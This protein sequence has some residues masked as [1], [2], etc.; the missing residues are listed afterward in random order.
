VL[1]ELRGHLE[2]YKEWAIES[3][4]SPDSEGFSLLKSI[5]EAIEMGRP[6]LALDRFFDLGPNQPEL[7]AASLSWE[8]AMTERE[9]LRS[10]L[11]REGITYD[12]DFDGGY[13][14]GD[15]KNGFLNSIIRVRHLEAWVVFSFREDGSLADIKSRTGLL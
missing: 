6:G 8:R 14:M 12:G 4:G 15:P 7:S 9:L 10:W 13:I 11:D 3:D 1:D 2:N 5:M